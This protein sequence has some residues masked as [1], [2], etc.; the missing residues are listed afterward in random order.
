MA[1]LAQARS[2][3][4]EGNAQLAEQGALLTMRA[5]SLR[6]MSKV[7]FQ[8]AAIVFRRVAFIRVAE[9]LIAEMAPSAPG[10]TRGTH[11]PV[12]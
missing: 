8:E 10:F 6:S 1:T 7:P 12:Y 9:S 3:K 2:G 5:N 4:A 11:Q